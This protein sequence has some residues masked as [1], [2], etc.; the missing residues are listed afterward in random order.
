MAKKHETETPAE[1]A[2]PP[3]TEFEQAMREIA[4]EAKKLV[5]VGMG[6]GDAYG[7][8]FNVWQATRPAV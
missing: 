7:L 1:D 3:P 8:A 5:D 4:C 2:P 6:T